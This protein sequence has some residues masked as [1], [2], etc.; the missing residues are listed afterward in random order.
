MR[1]GILGR[2]V[3]MTQI[4]DETGGTVPVTVVDTTDCY[5][6]QVK[7]KE[8][9][10]YAAVQVA[11]GDRKPQNVNK[12][13]TGHFKK[14]TVPARAM[15]KE[16]RVTPADDLSQLKAGQKLSGLMFAKGDRVDVI[17]VTKG[18]GFQGV[19][20]RHGYH[21]ADAT[22]GVHE[23]FRHAGSAGTNTFPGRILKNKGMPGHMGDVQ[24]TIKNIEVVQIHEKENLLLLRG[25]LPGAKSGVLLI[26]LTKKA[27]SIPTDR[28]LTV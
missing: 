24:R 20:K 8:T 18:K 19:M 2:K 5:I 11:F 4:F 17:G 9:D 14:A 15:M 21:G 12:A 1:L 7:T 16:I 3:G 26:R 10:G 22:H 28:K 27:K 13:K 23:Y 25:A 6:T